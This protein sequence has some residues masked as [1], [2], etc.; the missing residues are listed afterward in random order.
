MA[1]R[2]AL[3]SGSANAVVAAANAARVVKVFIV[4]VVWIFKGF[5]K[6][7]EKMD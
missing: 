6:K 1:G 7:G 5:L 3:F 2:S 4:V